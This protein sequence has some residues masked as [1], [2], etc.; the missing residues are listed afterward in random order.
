MK[1]FEQHARRFLEA[2]AKELD[3]LRDTYNGFD[4]GVFA[5]NNKMK[6]AAGMTRVVLIGRDFVI[7]I[8]KP[9]EMIGSW[10]RFGNCYQEYRNYKMTVEDGYDYLFAEIIKVKAGHHFY[11]IMPRVDTN[12]SYDDYAWDLE[13]LSEEEQNYLMDKFQDLHDENYGFD[14]YGD[15]KIFDYAVTVAYYMNYERRH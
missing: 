9:Q 14:E 11:Y 10:K 15:L 2:H 1:F 8:D 5:F 4:F 12:N 3:K 7:Q 6:F 13:F